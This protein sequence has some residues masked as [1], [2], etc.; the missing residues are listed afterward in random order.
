MRLA[1]LPG[2]QRQGIGAD[3]QQRVGDAAG[4]VVLGHHEHHHRHPTLFGEQEIHHRLR[5]LL[6]HGVGNLR[7]RAALELRLLPAGRHQNVVPAER[8]RAPRPPRTVAL[9]LVNDTP[10]RVPVGDTGQEAVH[11]ALQR[12][13]REQAGH[14]RAARNVGVDVGGHANAAFPCCL[15]HVQRPFHLAPVLAPGR[16]QVGYLHGNARFLADSQR[17]GDGL[18]EGAA[19]AAHVRRVEAAG[20]LGHLRQGHELGRVAVASGGVDQTR[21]QAEGAVVHRLADEALHAHQ[22]VGARRPVGKSHDGDA[23]GAVADE[24]HQVHGAALIADALVVFAQPLPS[25][26]QV[27]VQKADVFLQQIK[28]LRRHRRRREAAVADH[29]GGDAL[30]HLAVGARRAQQRKVRMGVRVDEPR[31]HDAAAGVD[32]ARRVAFQGGGHRGDTPAADADVGCDARPPG[33]V[34]YRAVLDEQVK[35]HDCVPSVGSS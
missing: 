2:G 11:A 27:G 12:P 17:L 33:A 5:R 10:P 35:G 18:L 24:R 20:L 19:L 28:R 15:D 4:D 16:L 32:A 8:P 13:G 23:H 29:L 3:H 26:G 34:D 30:A 25:P 21:G 22:F 7:H 31:R 6:A 9:A 14:R 1:A